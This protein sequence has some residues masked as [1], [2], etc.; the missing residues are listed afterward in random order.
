M[1]DKLT[2][3]KTLPP[4]IN[5]GLKG[6]MGITP[7][8]FW[9]WGIGNCLGIGWTGMGTGCT[10]FCGMGITFWGWG[11]TIT[12]GLAFGAGI[13]RA[14]L[15]CIGIIGKCCPP[16]PP[17]RPRKSPKGKIIGS[18]FTNTIHCFWWC[19]IVTC[20]RII[21]GSWKLYAMQLKTMSTNR[22]F[23]GG[24]LQVLRDFLDSALDFQSLIQPCLRVRKIRHNSV[25]CHPSPFRMWRDEASLAE[26]VVS[27]TVQP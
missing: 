17:R 24:Y 20:N 23:Y 11:L 7:P 16:S 18:E 10:F 22:K 4:C 6:I 13:G 2:I 1:M 5:P 8:F 25:L 12:G 21:K 3:G 9:G 14:S 15:G 26:S 19:F 27:L